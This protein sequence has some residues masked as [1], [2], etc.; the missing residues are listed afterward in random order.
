MPQQIIKGN[1]LQV[2]YSGRTFGYATSHTLTITGNT[3]DI[4]SKDHGEWGGS[5][6]SNLT[7]EVTGEYFYTDMD[8]DTLFDLMIFK[9]PVLIK[10]AKVN[11]Y[12]DNG[13]LGL[14]GSQP[15][16][17]PAA[18]GK[19]GYAVITSLTANANTGEKASYS[20]TFTGNGPLTDYDDTITSYYIDVIYKEENLEYGMELM[21]P[22]Y[23]GS[24]TSAWTYEGSFSPTSVLAQQIDISNGT[25]VDSTPNPEDA[26]FR[27]YFSGPY[28]PVRL[29]YGN[30]N[31]ATVTICENITTIETSA[32]TGSSIIN[33]NTNSLMHYGKGCLA[34]C[35]FL[36]RV[37][38][39]SGDNY[40]NASYI[41]DG[42]FETCVRLGDI[43][44]GDSCR[45]IAQ[46][47]FRDCME[48]QQAYFGDSLTS[49]GSTAF[50]MSN[51]PASKTFHIYTESAPTLGTLPFGPESMQTIYLHNSSSVESFINSNET[52]QQYANADIQLYQ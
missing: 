40:L 9:R 32:F 24:V 22:E 4:A 46:D 33:L 41:D 45:H 44:I 23:V 18:K 28:V 6:I 43:H 25:L 27:Y 8:Y 5:D 19:S 21:N 1:Q 10:V 20:I 17:Y 3:T 50:I 30:N 48:I 34:D 49:I 37:N 14:G 11:N 16:W 31:L 13:L 35:N 29:F 39:P 47:A 12:D 52:W 2:F 15:R 38:N 26:K 7:W 42:A 51:H 36:Y